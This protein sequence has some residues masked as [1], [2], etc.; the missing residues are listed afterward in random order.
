VS[1]Q[2]RQEIKKTKQKKG[3]QKL[4]KISTETWHYQKETERHPFNGARKVKPFC[5]LMKQE[6]IE[7]QWHQLDHMQIISTSLQTDSHA[8]TSSFF[9][10][11]TAFPDVQPTAPKH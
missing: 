3:K 2:S 5:I 6:M 8:S 11:T 9:Y 1:Q 7:W 4:H 10:K